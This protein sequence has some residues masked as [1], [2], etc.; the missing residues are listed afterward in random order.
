MKTMKTIAV[1]TTFALSTAGAFATP[2][3]YGS[4]DANFG[5]NPANASSNDAGYYVWS[6]NGG[7]DW[8]V[9]WTGNDNGDTGWYD[10]FG[11][12]NLQNLE[13]GSV[14]GVQFESNQSDSVNEFA[15]IGGVMDVITYEGEA[16]PGWDGFDFSLTTPSQTQVIDFA[17][18][19]SLFTNLEVA[20]GDVAGTNLYIGDQLNTPDVQV[21]WY[22]PDKR[23]RMVQRFEVSQV[24]EPGT[25]ALFGLGLM[26]IGVRYA[27]KS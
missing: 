17:L 16:G 20:P 24:P 4:T 6:K 12:V 3:Y 22:D 23:D 19:S 14:Q 7:D 9:R 2:V 10:W 27:K 8:S 11:T 1:A 13:T 25:L 15:N 21:Q 5:T 18:G 26:G